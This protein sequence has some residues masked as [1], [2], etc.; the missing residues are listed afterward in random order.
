M[1]YHFSELVDAKKVQKLMERFHEMTKIPC[2]LIDSKG[3]V[4]KVNESKLLSSGWQNIC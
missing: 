3:I 1:K 4:L 2:T